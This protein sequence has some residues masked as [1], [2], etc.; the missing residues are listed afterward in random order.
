MKKFAH[1]HWEGLFIT[2][3]EVLHKFKSLP[4]GPL[5]LPLIW[6][7]GFVFLRTVFKKFAIQILKK[8][9][10]MLWDASEVFQKAYL[11]GTEKEQV[12]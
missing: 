12:L 8:D 9:A 4:P 11:K 2:W 7:Y 6:E 3:G 5:T 1:V 10:I